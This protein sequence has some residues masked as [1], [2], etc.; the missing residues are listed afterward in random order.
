MH[1]SYVNLS[2]EFNFFSSFFVSDLGFLILTRVLGASSHG[3]NSDNR[4]GHQ[5]FGKTHVFY[6]KQ[7]VDP[8]IQSI[9]LVVFIKS[10]GEG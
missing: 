3:V 4:K 10:V 9:A 1:D 6:L 7:F 8:L 5:Y 2:V